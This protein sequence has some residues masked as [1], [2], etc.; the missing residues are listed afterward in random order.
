MV[1]SFFG[2]QINAL[3]CFALGN[4]SIVMYLLLI[5]FYLLFFYQGERRSLAVS[6]P[7]C[8][9]YLVCFVL[10]PLSF[11]K[12]WVECIVVPTLYSYVLGGG[13]GCWLPNLPVDFCHVW[14]VGS[15]LLLCLVFAVF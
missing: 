6:P 2:I 14:T 1:T 15:M 8:L 4:L 3:L 10:F 9:S 13:G 5:L 7:V 12:V 11:L